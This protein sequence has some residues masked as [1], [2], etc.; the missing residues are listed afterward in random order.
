MI[1]DASGRF[2]TQQ[3]APRLALVKVLVNV[4]VEA[5][6]LTLDAP[7]M[8][9]LTVSFEESPE[10]IEVVVWRFRG[11]A[12]CP[13]A[14]ADAWFSTYLAKPVRLVRCAPDMVRVANRAWVAYDAPIPFSDAYP[15]LLISVAS[16]DALNDR[17]GGA[18]PLPMAR[19]RPNVV[20]RGCAAFAEDDWKTIEIGGTVI[21]VVKPCDR[22][23][24]TTVDPLTAEQGKEP[25][26]TL[27]KFRRSAA[28]VLFGQ[29]CAAR[30][31][32]V[33]R[34]GDR[35]EVKEHGRLDLLPA[36]WRITA[37]G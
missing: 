7:G 36:E 16:L 6:G 15:I 5:D 32:G 24:I 25:L 33:L 18:L 17:I 11:E 22:C 28:G 26:K 34:V 21:D 29:N 1:V 10:R 35:L 8:P 13:S 3:D 20:V 27:A 14:D 12:L 19:F 31:P 9:S 23:A 37:R 30:A 2:I 4:G